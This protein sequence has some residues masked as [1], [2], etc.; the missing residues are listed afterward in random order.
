MLERAA[1][2]DDDESDGA[3]GA[4]EPVNVEDCPAREDAID[5]LEL[6]VAGLDRIADIAAGITPFTRG[7]VNEDRD[8]DMPASD[9]LAVHH[10]AEALIKDINYMGRFV[11]DAV[12]AVCAMA[13][14]GTSTAEGEL[15]EAWRR[16]TPANRHKLVETVRDL[17]KGAEVT[18]DAVVRSG[19]A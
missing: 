10:L 15:I 14:G 4:S 9:V 2:K 16:M 17:A 8:R 7:T 3:E 18:E 1:R 19:G 12:Q 13:V 6:C 5:Y 11:R